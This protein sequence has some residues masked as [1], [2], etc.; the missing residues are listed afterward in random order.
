MNSE[1]SSFAS[2]ASTSSFS[3]PSENFSEG[4]ND[5]TSRNSAFSVSPMSA[6]TVTVNPAQVQDPVL[7]SPTTNS[8]PD[9][10]I[11]DAPARINESNPAITNFSE[12]AENY[13]EKVAGM[14]S[15]FATILKKCKELERENGGLRREAELTKA[16]LNDKESQLHT[17]QTEMNSQKNELENLRTEKDNLEDVLTTTRTE[18]E[19]QKNRFDA[20]EI[21][22][23][24][25]RTD[26]ALQLRQMEE[27]HAESLRLKE[28]ELD[29]R[30]ALVNNLTR[31]N[32]RI[33][34]EINELEEE[35][36]LYKDTE[37]E[38]I[39]ELL[40]AENKILESKK[41][42]EAAISQGNMM[43]SVQ[44]GF[45]LTAAVQKNRASVDEWSKLETKLGGLSSTIRSTLKCQFPDLQEA[46]DLCR[47]T[48][49]KYEKY[50]DENLEDQKKRREHA[51][52]ITSEGDERQEMKEDQVSALLPRNDEESVD[53]IPGPSQPRLRKRGADK[54]LVTNVKRASL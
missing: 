40:T 42:T 35:L 44:I 34:D 26:H 38:A 22:W 29:G 12:V 52:G 8:N 50:L 45:A 24:D 48:K 47:E 25:E 49:E 6:F 36:E 14:N 30:H 23:A 37:L 16:T 9:A 19:T 27:A 32:Y 33:R 3:I 51:H 43:H 39:E 17:I 31:R 15:A 54:Q 41:E 11:S 46:L 7:P 21:N 5:T 28:V 18:M 13:Y 10:A 1:S 53:Q 20:L 4:Q 2:M